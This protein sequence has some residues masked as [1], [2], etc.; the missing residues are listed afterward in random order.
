[1]SELYK[2]DDD[3]V[4]AQKKLVP[5]TRAL[6]ESMQQ[7]SHQKKFRCEIFDITNPV[8]KDRYTQ[9]WDSI[10][11][12]PSKQYVGE[13]TTFTKSGQYLVALRWVEEVTRPSAI[14]S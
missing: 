10:L 5:F 6:S 8:Q 7:A 4:N 9:T 12:D 11:N 13:E 14:P 2:L 1:M 3:F